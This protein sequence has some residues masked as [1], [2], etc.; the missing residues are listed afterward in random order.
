[1]IYNPWEETPLYGGNNPIY[2]N[3]YSRMRW[4]EKYF[5]YKVSPEEEEVIENLENNENVKNMPC[6][7][8]NGSVKVIG[9]KIVIKLENTQ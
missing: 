1:M 3:R 5:G 2:I 8:D 7:P 6:W 4:I 9:E